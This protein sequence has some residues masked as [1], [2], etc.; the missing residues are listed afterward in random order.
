MTVAETGRLVIR[1]LSDTDA[2]FIL[3]L[4]NDPDF[5]R[6]IGDRNVRSLDDAVRYI[7]AGPIASYDRHDAWDRELVVGQGQHRPGRFAGEPLAPEGREEGVADIHVR[8]H[9]PPEETA[10]PDRRPGFLHL[11]LEEPEA[12]AFVA[13]DRPGLD[14]AHRIVE[15]ADVAVADVAKEIGVVD[16]RHDER[17]VGAGKPAD[18]EALGFDDGHRRIPAVASLAA[19]RSTVR[20]PR[21]VI[22]RFM[23]FSNCTLDILDSPWPVW[24]IQ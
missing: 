4:V 1:R 16:Q 9:L 13:R 12:V 21:K 24:H 6:N 19:S 3:E 8:E 17:R 11:H 23:A 20:M 5:L 18:H 14:V 7:E 22:F 10:H 2:P 15:A